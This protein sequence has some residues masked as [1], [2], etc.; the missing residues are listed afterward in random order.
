MVTVLSQL[1]VKCTSL[2]K[3]NTDRH[4]VNA[5][6][7]IL[8]HLTSPPNALLRALVKVPLYMAAT[9]P[10]LVRYGLLLHIIPIHSGMRVA[11]YFR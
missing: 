11:T 6:V 4:P 1:T 10:A 9:I 2:V 7:A 8:W 3:L 5:L